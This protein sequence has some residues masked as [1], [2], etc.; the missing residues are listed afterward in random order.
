MQKAKIGLFLHRFQQKK[1]PFKT[2]RKVYVK[3]KK[4]TFFSSMMYYQ[5]WVLVLGS[6]LF[7]SKQPSQNQDFRS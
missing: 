5:K 6:K 2:W 1:L 3:N 4:E 7:A